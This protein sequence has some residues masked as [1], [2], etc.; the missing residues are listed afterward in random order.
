MPMVTPSSTNPDVTEVGDMIFRVCFID[1]FQ[2]I[3]S[4]KFAREHEGLKAQKAAILYDQ[5]A[6]YAVGLQEEFDKAF[7]ELGGE[8]VAKETYQAGDQDFRRS[9]RPSAT[10]RMSFLSRLLHRRRQ[11]CDPGEIGI[12]VPLLGGDG[13]DSEKLA[14]IAGEAI[15]GCF[16][17]NHYSHQDPIRACRISSRSTR[18]AT[19]ERP[20]AWRSV[21]CGPHRV[22]RDRSDRRLPAP[23]SRPSWRRP[24][25][26]R[27]HRQDLD[28]RGSQRRQAGRHARNEGRRADVRDDDRAV[29]KLLAV[30]Y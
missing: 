22:R 14:E 17:S 21:R 11:H 5:V 4:A 29:R 25:I 24:R 2:G 19:A 23:T 28:R 30:S 9:S 18:S 7:K 15:D 16:Y 26:S 8:I 10:S 3:V 12:T 27:R 6:A 1:P 20:T 13:W